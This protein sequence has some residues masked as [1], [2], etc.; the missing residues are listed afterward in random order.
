M[1]TRASKLLYLDQHVLEWYTQKAQE[2]EISTNQLMRDVLQFHYEQR[3][4]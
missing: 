2:K 4:V 3:D 1:H